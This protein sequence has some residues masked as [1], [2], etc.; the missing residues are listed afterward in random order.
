MS[1]LALGLLAGGVHMLVL[2]LYRATIH[3]LSRFP[4][5]KLATITE[6]YTAFYDVV[7]GGE[8]VN[9]LRVLHERYGPVVRIGPNTL[10]FA[11][12]KAYTE[13]YQGSFT[14]Y[15][16][17]YQNT[18]RHCYDSSFVLAHVP[19][20]RLRKASLTPLFSRSAILK[21]EHLVQQKVDKLIEG[22]ERHTNKDPVNIMFAFLSTTLDVILEY[23]FATCLNALDDPNFHL[24]TLVSMQKTIPSL[25][26]QKYLPFISS[27]PERFPSVVQLVA[28]DL[29]AF[30]ECNKTLME[31]INRYVENPDLLTAASHDTIFHH[32]I[33]PD[34]QKSLSKQSL[35]H[36]A[37]VLMG[38]GS[39]TI[40]HTC[41][42]GTM[43]LL[44]NDGARR[45]L[46]QELQRAW[47]NT[48]Q[49]MRYAEL[50][51]LP[52]L[53]AC[54]KESLR[55]SHGVISPLPREVGESG[56]IICGRSIPPKTIV[57]IGNCFV[58][59]NSQVFENPS[60]F[61]PERWLQPNSKDLE[62]YLVAFSKGPRMC[63]GI[64]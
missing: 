3:P 64:K 55:L 37:L 6:L 19:T 31:Q 49:P 17:F 53:T 50:E 43:H 2:A 34:R 38:A 26:L 30:D 22:L 12:P 45:K 41:A 62:R 33:V 39:D 40:A 1:L 13:I 51:K 61:L 46:L 24:P 5:P 44:H 58:H 4:G 15:E 18:F 32:L 60:E 63:L 47:P 11:D 16:W 52:Y 28:P 14:K 56:A 8:L 20:Y 35:L 59:M 54:I 21:L 42:V 36:E 29:M 23:C 27:I 7:L 9:H 10:H 48:S 57:G 25:W